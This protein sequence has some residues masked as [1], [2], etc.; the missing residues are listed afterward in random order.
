VVAAG[1]VAA[2][3]GDIAVAGDGDVFGVEDRI[4]TSDLS[5]SSMPKFGVDPES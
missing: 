5:I 2:V 1:E 3:A 4:V